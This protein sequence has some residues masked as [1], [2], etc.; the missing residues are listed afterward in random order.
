M[1]WQRA[2]DCAKSIKTHRFKI[3]NNAIYEHENNITF[4]N[5]K[6]RKISSHLANIS[7]LNISKTIS[8]LKS[9]VTKNNTQ[10]DKMRARKLKYLLTKNNY[11]LSSSAEI[12]IENFTNIEIPSEISDLLKHGLANPI[13]G[14]MKSSQILSKFE[15][16]FDNWISYAK[17]NNFDIFTINKVKSLLFLS[18][19]E[20]KNCTMSN[21]SRK[22]LIKFLC[23]HPE[24]LFLNVDKTKNLAYVRMEDYLTKF[25]EIFS[26]DKFQKIKKNPIQK[27]LREYRKLIQT[28]APFLTKSDQFLL[29]PCENLKTGYGLLKLHKK[30]APLRPIVSSLNSICSGAETFLHNLIKPIVKNCKFSIK[31]TKH[32]KNNFPK[33]SKKFNEINHE[34]ISIDC[35]SLYT[36]V[37]ITRVVDHILDIIYKKDENGA[38]INIDQFFPE[39]EKTEIIDGIENKKTIKPPPA[40]ILKI[41]FPKHI[42]KI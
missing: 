21:N 30:N 35:V 29:T 10:A 22:T 40:Y 8:S 17:K 9:K 14:H 32:F 38:F 42:N 2:S 12:S 7:S 13:G 15:I 4:F 19:D 18:F 11:P 5:Q 3:L 23:D 34:I 36:S 1:I 26:P 31:S 25:D 28:L 41:F 20:F 6:F 16:F 37:N 27:N 24:N 39:F 33:F